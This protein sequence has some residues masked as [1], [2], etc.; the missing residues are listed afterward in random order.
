MVNEVL[1][2]QTDEILACVDVSKRFV[3]ELLTLENLNRTSLYQ[4][5]L[6][7]TEVREMEKKKVQLYEFADLLKS[8]RDEDHRAQEKSATFNK[9]KEVVKVQEVR[10][11]KRAFGEDDKRD[12]IASESSGIPAS[13][14]VAPIAP[15]PI[16]RIETGRV[17]TE[18]IREGGRGKP[19]HST[20]STQ[21]ARLVPRIPP[22]GRRVV[23]RSEKVPSSSSGPGVTAPVE[24][25][26]GPI[27]SSEPEG[28]RAKSRTTRKE[29]GKEVLVEKEKGSTDTSTE[30]TV[31]V[32]GSIFRSLADFTSSLS[33]IVGE[34]DSRY[35]QS[36]TLAWKN[37]L[38]C[39]T[40]AKVPTIFSYFCLQL[41]RRSIIY[42]NFDD[43]VR[44]H[45]C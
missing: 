23:T 44:R 39:Q 45:W 8:V 42:R 24:I 34:E 26:R 36:R 27:P 41:I 2:R 33:G 19:S 3:V 37:N 40:L 17:R 35:L 15:T 28:T 14:D 38:L 31:P 10:K 30:R 25:E 13:S 21:G 1:E 20:S 7:D 18:P 43:F 9:D 6:S 12:E 16:V 22:A 4:R 5:L 32:F 29:K 11:R